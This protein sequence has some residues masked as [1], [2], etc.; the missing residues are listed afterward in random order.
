[1]PEM[2]DNTPVLFPSLGGALSEINTKRAEKGVAQ[3]KPND[4]SAF[5]SGINGA[6][7]R[8]LWLKNL[9]NGTPIPK[10]KAL[11]VVSGVNAALQ[12]VGCKPLAASCLVPSIS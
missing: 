7:V 8:K 2:T 12:Q 9:L 5:L 10:E 3:I 4:W 11:H 1:M 6:T